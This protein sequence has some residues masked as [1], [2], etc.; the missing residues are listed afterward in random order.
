MKR[1][2]IFALILIS[3]AAICGCDS[4][5]PACEHEYVSQITKEATYDLE[6]ETQYTCTKCGDAYTESIAK[7]IVPTR[8]LEQELKALRY[9]RG[10]FS[11]TIG[12][13]MNRAVEDADIECLTGDEA[14]KKGYL[15]K[16]D[17]NNFIENVKKEDAYL[18]SDDMFFIRVSGY[19]V[20]NLDL[21]YLME[22]ND[23]AIECIVMA[24]ENGD[25]KMYTL[26]L[27]RS[28]Q[29]CAILIMF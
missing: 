4:A 6:G 2:C 12:E 16:E 28:L 27:S 10:G 3:I 24:D 5:P 25:I 1:L 23:R 8:G 19:V 11:I 29:T 22:Y 21:P 17:A 18:D 15:T 13:L 9:E 26:G 7:L 20:Q 14:V